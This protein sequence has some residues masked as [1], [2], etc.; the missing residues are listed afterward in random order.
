M[1][2][3]IITAKGLGCQWG[4]RYRIKQ[5]DWEIEEKSRWIV[6]GMNGSGKTTLLSIL[7]GYQDYSH[8]TLLYRG[9]DYRELDILSLRKQMGWISNSY[10]DRIYQ[11]ESVLDLVL[12]G[13]SGTLG[14]EDGC[15]TDAHI[16]K[17]KRLLLQVGLEDKM[18]SPYNWLSKG[19]RQNILI[20][21]ALLGQPEVLVLDEPMTGLDVVSK[22]RMMEF[23][24][25][26]AQ[27]RQHTMLYVTHHFE[28]ISPELFDRCLLLR[29]G[30]VYQ[31]GSVAEVINSE[32][33]SD[34][35]QKKVQVVQMKNSYYQLD[36]QR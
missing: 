1:D 13:L 27:K 10:F 29:N 23:V 26:I 32:T 20:L 22:Q 35:L 5:I 15:V 14:L 16:R 17:L 30:Q 7:A 36:F 31:T 33:I 4:E 19:E 12:S 3:S 28:E 18:D 25:G 2:G 24:R 34:F 11:H 21:R 8:G 6:L 9:T